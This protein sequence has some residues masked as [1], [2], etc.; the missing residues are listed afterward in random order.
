[1]FISMMRG[2]TL[3]IAAGAFVTVASAQDVTLRYAGTLPTTHHNAEGQYM[4]AEKVKEKTGGAVEVEVYPAGQLYKAREIP[5]AI[6]SGGADMG[7]NLTSVWSTD[8]VSEINDLPF[9]FRDHAHAAAAW[10]PEGRLYKAF[11]AEMDKRGMMTTHVM[12][13]GSLFDFGNNVRSVKG[14]DDFEGMKIRGYGKLAAEGLR[15]LGASPVVMS[16][17]EMYLAIQRGTIDGAITGVT[18]LESRKIWEV[19]EYSTITGATFGVMAV[20]ISKSRWSELSEEHKAAIL[21]AGKEVFEWSVT[22]SATRD[23]ASTQFLKDQGVDTYVLTP[24]DK[25]AWRELFQPAYDAWND[26][27]EDEHRAIVEWVGSL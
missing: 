10:A 21:E 15:A 14:Q 26:R 11:A 16:P 27:A 1:M 12:F 22:E 7:F 6:V 17:G 8:P 13:F 2:F 20:N 25:A 9:L 18:S 5:T 19:V 24:E 23:A 4:F 3:A